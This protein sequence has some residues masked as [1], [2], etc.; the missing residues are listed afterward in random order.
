M[1]AINVIQPYKYLGM[2][3]FDDK[4]REILHEPFVN[5]ADTILDYWVKDIQGAENGFLILFSETPFPNYQYKL[6]WLREEF[7]GNWYKIFYLDMEG[8]L[9]PALFKYFT[10]APSEIFLQIKPLLPK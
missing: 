1:N 6:S 7:G 4:E 10:A 8:W 9:C 3:V 2:W 5:G